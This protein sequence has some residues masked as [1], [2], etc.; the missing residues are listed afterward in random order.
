VYEI[1]VVNC[2]TCSRLH[3][4]L[5][6]ISNRFV[7]S[8]MKEKKIYIALLKACKCMLNL[9]R[10]A[11]NYKLKQNRWAK[12]NGPAGRPWDQSSIYGE[13]YGGKDLRKR[14][15]K[16]RRSDCLWKRWWWQCGSDL[17]RL[18]RRWKTRMWMRLTERVREFI[19]KAGCRMLKRTVCNFETWGGRWSVILIVLRIFDLAKFLVHMA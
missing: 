10:L 11:E 14:C 18:V 7:L 16:K 1:G 17:C 9:P 5:L 8:W 3:V 13:V 15:V 19:P 4:R 12:E 2:S 6:L